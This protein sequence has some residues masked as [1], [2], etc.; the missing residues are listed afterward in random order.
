MN[1]SKMFF[2][3]IKHSKLLGH[4]PSK[5]LRNAAQILNLSKHYSVQ[6]PQAEELVIKEK[7]HIAKPTVTKWKR[8]PF[9]RNFFFGKF[10]TVSCSLTYTFRKIVYC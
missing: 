1:S 6:N 10:D 5:V 9:A 4:Y 2:H 7:I 8:P 3:L